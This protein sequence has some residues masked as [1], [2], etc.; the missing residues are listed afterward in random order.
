MDATR[1]SP[2]S[3]D[4]VRVCRSQSII[5]ESAGPSSHG[6]SPLHIA[7]FVHRIDTLS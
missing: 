2:N 1:V 7:L 5:T 3:G 6:S 4:A